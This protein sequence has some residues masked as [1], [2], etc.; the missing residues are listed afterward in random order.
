MFGRISTKNLYLVTLRIV[1][2]LIWEEDSSKYFF[3]S[4]TRYALVRKIGSYEYEDIYTKTIHNHW[5]VCT[6]GDTAVVSERPVITN[7]KWFT[8]N[9]VLMLLKELNPTYLSEGKKL[10]FRK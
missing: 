3:D 6:Q 9:E 4:E 8:N 2:S 5:S 1:D 7:K 10:L